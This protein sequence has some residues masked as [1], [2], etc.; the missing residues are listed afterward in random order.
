[1]YKKRESLAGQDFIGEAHARGYS[2]TVTSSNNSN[3]K[4]LADWPGE[5]QLAVTAKH[6]SA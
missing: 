6:K 3:N 1:L 4:P 2:P 5:K